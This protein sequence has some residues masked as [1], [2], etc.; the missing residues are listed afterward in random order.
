M[1]GNANQSSVAAALRSETGPAALAALYESVSDVEVGLA[2][3]STLERLVAAVVHRLGF[4]LASVHVT[5]PQGLLVTVTVVGDEETR[6]GGET[7]AASSAGWG[8]A[9]A[10]GRRDGPEGR[11]RWLDAVDV[12]PWG[13]AGRTRRPENGIAVALRSPT[14]GLIG[15]LT[16]E[17]PHN[18][19]QPSPDELGL[20]EMFAGVAAVAIEH[21]R[22]GRSEEHTSELQSHVNIVCRL[23]LEKKKKKT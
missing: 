5:Q 14:D 1:A 17:V 21:Q 3:E 13:E 10:S 20:L 23:L 12:E 19:R 16:V 2:L 4:R 15:V 11:I 7:G 18:D 22:R 9:L 6:L 8:G